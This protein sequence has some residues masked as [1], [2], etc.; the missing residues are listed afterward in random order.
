MDT[1]PFQEWKR[2]LMRSAGAAAPVVEKAM[3]DPI[4]EVYFRRGCE[5]TLFHLLT[6]AADQLHPAPD[7][8]AEQTVPSP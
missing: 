7:A 1:P 3:G 6:Y 2:D 4:L 5:P 8:R